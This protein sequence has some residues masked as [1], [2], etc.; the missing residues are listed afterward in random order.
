MGVPMSGGLGVLRDA[1]GDD[2]YTTGIFGQ[3]TGYWFGTGLLLEGAGADHYD[4]WWYVHGSAAHFAVAALLDDAGGDTYQVAMPGDP[5]RNTSVGVGHDF[6]IGWLVDRDGDDIYHAPN[7]SL[8]AGN[9]AGFGFFLDLAGND[10]YTATSDFSFGNASIETP[11]DTLR[12]A[13]GTIG[14]FVDRGGTDGYTRPTPAPIA[15]NTTWTQTTHPGMGEHAG[16]VDAAS[17][18]VGLG[19]D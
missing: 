13:A 8:G 10:T 12:I 7:L 14:L 3:G 9:A 15:E 19:I 16:G 1:T 18:T 4:G 2:T 11:G 5:A 6:S 17:G